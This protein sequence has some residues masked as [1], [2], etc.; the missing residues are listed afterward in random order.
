MIIHT[1]RQNTPE[2]NEIRLGKVTASP[3]A[4]LFVKGT[5]VEHN[6][7]TGAITYAYEKAAQIMTGQDRKSWSNQYTEWGHE[8]E[9]KA[10]ISYEQESG[11]IVDEIGFFEVDNRVGFS[12]DGLVGEDGQ[13]EIKCPEKPTE[14][15]RMMLDGEILKTYQK[16]TQFGL[17]CTKRKWCDVIYFHPHFNNSLKINRVE[18][19]PAIF[20]EIE[21]IIPAFNTY[22]DMIIKQLEQ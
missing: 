1:M 9:P 3:C 10:R 15:V 7:G 8:H 21:I 6:W 22:V 16:Q 12:P 2:W 19:D 14:F 20:K 5:K 4:C 17:W 18:P 11:N 13:I